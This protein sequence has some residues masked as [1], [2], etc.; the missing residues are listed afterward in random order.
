MSWFGDLFSVLFESPIRPPLD[1]DPRA[2][3][4]IRPTLN[5]ERN[6]DRDS[7][8]GSA[9]SSDSPSLFDIFKD[10]EDKGGFFRW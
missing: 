1:Q 2:Q 10:D 9:N 5:I 4:S 3:F 7:L 8:W 6:D